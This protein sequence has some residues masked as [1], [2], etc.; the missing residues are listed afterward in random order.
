ME[1]GIHFV[2]RLPN[3]K[4]NQCR[5]SWAVS[6]LHPTPEFPGI[7]QNPTRG[8]WCPQEQC[9][10]FPSESPVCPVGDLLKPVPPVRVGNSWGDSGL[11]RPFPHCPMGSRSPK[12]TVDSCTRPSP[13]L[14][15]PTDLCY[16]GGP[17]WEATGGSSPQ[18]AEPGPC[19]CAQ[20]KAVTVDVTLRRSED[21]TTRQQ[22]ADLERS[23]GKDRAG[24]EGGSCREQGLGKGIQA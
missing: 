9:S 5:I 12:S 24:P 1:L 7:C 8:S 17:C 23:W 18:T 20:R 3:E 13:D 11:G 15:L 21:E 10:G 14:T 19:A 22:C 4:L 6:R 2:L 16:M